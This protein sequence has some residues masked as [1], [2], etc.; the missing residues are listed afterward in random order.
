MMEEKGKDVAMGFS[1]PPRFTNFKR[2]SEILRRT[3]T[4]ISSPSYYIGQ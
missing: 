2:V 3:T 4:K 1:R